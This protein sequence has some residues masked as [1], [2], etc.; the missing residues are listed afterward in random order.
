MRGVRAIVELKRWAVSGH[1]QARVETLLA[2][3]PECSFG[4][5]LTLV[6]ARLDGRW[7]SLLRNAAR[8]VSQHFKTFD[9]MEARTSHGCPCTIVANVITPGDLASA[10]RARAGL[11]GGAA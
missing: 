6:D 8:E 2:H 7:I 3:L 5:R 1:D 9:A 10:N 4:L 11:E